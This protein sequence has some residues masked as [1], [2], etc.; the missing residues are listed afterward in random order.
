MDTLIDF[1]AE[2]RGAYQRNDWRASY[3]A[4]VGADE[5]GPMQADDLEAYSAAAWRIG[6]G[7]E[8]VRLAERT[9][10]RLVRTDPAAAAMKA[11]E[12]GLEW[13]ARGHDAV[14]RQWAERARALLAGVPANRTHGCLAYLDAVSALAAGDSTAVTRAATTL[15]HVAADTAEPTLS[16]LTKVVDGVVA[17][18][19]SHVA[20]GYRLLDEAL[21]PMLDEHVPLE[22]AG[23]IYRLVLRPTGVV[24]ARH[25]AAWTESM[26]RWVVITRVV[27]DIN[28]SG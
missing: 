15:R 22:W 26:E 25:R 19:E 4:Y 1:L 17:L 8:A 23:D 28:A 5:L 12:L 9:Y 2:A 14:S 21:L 10:A 6:R 11:A 13:Q 20:E 18:L 7:S 27:I 24:D 3:A 16:V